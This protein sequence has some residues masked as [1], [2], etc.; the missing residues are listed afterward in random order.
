MKKKSAGE[1]IEQLCKEYQENPQ[2]WSF[3]KSPPAS[4][5]ESYVAYLIR[6]RGVFPKTGFH[7]HFQLHRSRCQRH[8]KIS[9]SSPKN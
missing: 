2:G 7:L 3:W 9:A 8:F 5:S 6:K 1:I 4:S